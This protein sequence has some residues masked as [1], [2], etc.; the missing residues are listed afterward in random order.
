MRKPIPKRAEFSGRR[1]VPYAA[2]TPGLWLGP[3]MRCDALAVWTPVVLN[4]RPTMP[5]MP[6]MPAMPAIGTGDN[7]DLGTR[8]AR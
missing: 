6:T 7:V 2:R 8:Y 4:L 5:T 1:K 3:P